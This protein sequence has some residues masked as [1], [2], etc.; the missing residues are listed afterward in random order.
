M[1]IKGWKSVAASSLLPLVLVV[2]CETAAADPV[3]ARN[4]SRF[5]TAFLGRDL[6]REELRRLT[7]EFVALHSAAGKSTQAIREHARRF[8]A[9]TEALRR[10]PEGPA[11]FTMRHFVIALN[12]FDPPLQNT[13]H[14]RLLTAPDPV[15]VVDRRS[16]RLMTE[17]DVIALANLRRFATSDGPPRHRDLSRPQIEELVAALTAAVGGDTGNMP[18]FFGEAAAFWAGVRGAWDELD[19]QQRQLARAYA[20][21]MWRIQIPPRMYGLLWGLEPG[22]AT[23]RYADDV[24]ARISAITDINMRLGNLP[25]VMD[26]IFGP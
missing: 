20:G 15:R 14:L 8:G 3:V 13:L 7:D 12:Y 23:S 16:R 18:M 24:S 17:R 11:A 5:Y 1:P 22:A 25:R 4:V 26:A 21:R 9:R 19:A 10:D 2:C 6:G